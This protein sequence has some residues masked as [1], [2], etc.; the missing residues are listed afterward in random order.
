MLGSAVEMDIL[1]R[2]G[3]LIIDTAVHYLTQ[4]IFREDRYNDTSICDPVG[5]TLAASLVEDGGN[6]FLFLGTVADDRR[7]QRRNKR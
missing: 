4:L 1:H 3:G 7:V 5:G 6:S 2:A